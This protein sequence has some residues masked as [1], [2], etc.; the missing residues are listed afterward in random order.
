MKS[1]LFVLLVGVIQLMPRP[2]PAATPDD[3]WLW[4]EDIQGKRA[5]DW[6]A[7][8]DARTT[9]ALA[10]SAEFK[11]LDARFLE[12][13]NSEAQIPTVSK[14]GDRYYN[15]WRDA[16]HV[17]GLWRRT[18]LEEYRKEAPAWET[19]IDLDSL[20]R[21]ESENWVWHGALPLRRA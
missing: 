18:T 16:R 11:A 8:Q 1:M 14:I 2:V 13:L 15:F 19:V 6:V 3:P 17:R 7:Q 10:G 9:R 20:A 21:T 5:L 12:I 4:L